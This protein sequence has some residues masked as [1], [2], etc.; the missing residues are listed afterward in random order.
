MQEV[1]ECSDAVEKLDGMRTIPQQFRSLLV[2]VALLSALI[3]PM[4]A[5]GAD[6]TPT[7]PA[8]LTGIFNTD[9]DGVVVDYP[10]FIHAVDADT[11]AIA[12]ISENGRWVVAQDAKQNLAAA[13]VPAGANFTI[14]GATT[15]TTV[16]PKSDEAAAAKLPTAFELP[17]YLAEHNITVLTPPTSAAE[18]GG[19]N[20]IMR[21]LLI[22]LGIA[23]FFVT[24]IVVIAVVRRLRGQSGGSRGGGIH[25]HGKMRKEA[26][27]DRPDIRFADIAGCEECVEE[28]AETVQFL[29]NPEQ[30]A[31][32]GARMPH[33]V[34]LHGPPGTGKTLLAKAV[35]G[36]AGVP[37]YAISGSD[38]VDTYVGV[39]ASRVRDLFSRMRNHKDGAVLFVDEIDAIGR[40]RGSG[41]GGADTEREGT[42]NALL[43]ELDGFATTDRIVVI[44]ATN[45]LDILDQA[46]IRPGRFDRHVQVSLPAERGR[47]EILAV[48]S[49]GKPLADLS[50]LDEIAHV[51]AGFSGADLAKLM[52]EAA[53][54]AARDQRAII[55]M[56][57]LQEGMLR[58]IAGP[59]RKDRAIADGELERIA[60]HEAGHALSAELCATHAKTQRV[61]ILPRGQ[62]A[63][64]AMYGA[65]D[66]TLVSPEQ[67]HERMVVIMAGRAAEQ[68]RFGSVSSGAANDL[69]QANG[70]ARHAV[71]T[72]GFSTRV[73]QIITGA[74]GQG[75]NMS[76]G[77][78]N[79]VDEEIA[80]MVEDA[81]ADAVGLLTAHHGHLERLASALLEQQE[82]DRA[83]LTEIL[84]DTQAHTLS[85]VPVWRSETIPVAVAHTPPV[86]PTCAGAGAPTEV[87]REMRAPAP[88]PDSSTQERLTVGKHMREAGQSLR[89]AGKALRRAVKRRRVPAA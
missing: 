88:T 79:A 3:M 51:T 8:S 12:A 36:E 30:F 67:L 70:M 24:V 40:A 45:R 82:L 22:P 35:A 39:G 50:D 71:E 38:F 37:F 20:R 73:G 87:G 64:L 76:A 57:D 11:F 77:V 33:G 31:A 72:L 42:L 23:A 80:R 53:I 65:T 18:S 52:N 13:Q 84:G 48:H 1:G 44:A 41:Q 66:S 19:S 2:A 81:Y 15:D 75:L 62:A 69:E 59:Q 29:S 58:A 32:V 56:G 26:L 17:K 9:N 68:L 85:R 25:G 63:G 34:I 5:I 27:A 74:R 78:R 28:L 14:P 4:G 47:R 46:L 43:V 7:P 89:H 10:E 61:T 16:A 49:A 54:M 83:E 21:F 86:A 60:W 55:L 6:D